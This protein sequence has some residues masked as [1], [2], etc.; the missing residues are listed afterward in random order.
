[1]ATGTHYQVCVDTRIVRNIELQVAAMVG[2]HKSRWLGS[3]EWILPCTDECRKW[4]LPAFVGTV[5]EAV[6]EAEAA[7]AGVGAEDR[8]DIADGMAVGSTAWIGQL[9][10][11]TE[12]VERVWA[13]QVWVE[14]WVEQVWVE[15]V[16]VDFF[17]VVAVKEAEVAPFVAAALAATV[18]V[19]AK[20]IEVAAEQ[21]VL[22]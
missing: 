1:M 3:V 19:A 16:W 21:L 17:E 10:E 20:S 6:A 8:P 15:Q 12:R 22:L 11:R 14:G 5:A 13:G 4:T 9:V 2:D 18:V 7:V